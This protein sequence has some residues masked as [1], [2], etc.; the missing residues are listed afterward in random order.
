[1]KKIQQA[2]DKSLKMREWGPHVQAALNA[3]LRTV[4][5][6]EVM[7]GEGW[8]Q[9][10]WSTTLGPACNKMPE[11]AIVKKY[12]NQTLIPHVKEF[13]SGKENTG[14]HGTRKLRF[15]ETLRSQKPQGR[16]PAARLAASNAVSIS[17]H[18]STRR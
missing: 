8:F 13:F 5:P 14:I 4:P 3:V 6:P 7:S 15:F 10:F 12:Q 2:P 1:M 11:G 9:N 16:R 18:L 17:H